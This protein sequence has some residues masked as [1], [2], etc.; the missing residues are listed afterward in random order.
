MTG[1]TIVTFK[2]TLSDGTVVEKELKVKDGNNA[3]EMWLIAGHSGTLDDYIA[4]N[5]GEKGEQGEQGLEGPMGPMLEFVGVFD[6]VEELPVDVNVNSIA[7]VGTFFYFFNGSEWISLGS[8]A[9]PQGEKG[10]PGTANFAIK[11]GN[12][13]SNYSNNLAAANAHG[14][15]GGKEYWKYTINLDKA[16]YNKYPVCNVLLQEL[17]CDASGVPVPYT[18]HYFFNSSGANK[19]PNIVLML[20]LHEPATQLLSNTTGQYG[21]LG[22]VDDVQYEP[23][24]SVSYWY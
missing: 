9:G 14:T 12:F 15:I 10:D 13:S 8:F 11:S 20:I 6:T 24:Y 1:G 19:P 5:K 2:F 21:P 18:L 22:L 7:T 23:H 4:F 17:P 3:Y 16:T